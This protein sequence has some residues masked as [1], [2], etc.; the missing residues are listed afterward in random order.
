MRIT[1]ITSAHNA[2]DPATVDLANIHT[3]ELKATDCTDHHPK[4]EAPSGGDASSASIN[5]S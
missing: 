3:V 1:T 2:D 4:V 5:P